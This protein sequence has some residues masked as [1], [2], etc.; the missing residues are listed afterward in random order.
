MVVTG[1]ITEDFARRAAKTVR[2]KESFVDD[3]AMPV[4]GKVYPDGLRWIAF[5]NDSNETVPSHALMRIKTDVE[6]DGAF[7]VILKCTKPDTTWSR[8]YA[9]NSGTPILAGSYGLCRTSGD[10]HVAYDSGTPAADEGWGPKPGQWTAAKNYP[11]CLLVDGVKEAGDKIML[12]T[13]GVIEKG[14][15]KANG[16]IA[17]EGT[18]AISIW[19]GAGLWTTDITGMDPT[20]VNLGPPL[21]SGDKV[22][23]DHLNGTL[24][25]SKICSS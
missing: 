9:V 5:K 25:C 17:N 10:V 14:L 13:L 18:G 8:R 7:N 15:G 21:A 4:G 2:W 1:R 23:W 22:Q 16:T 20:A 3:S 19:A 6:I 11:S 12:A 24:V